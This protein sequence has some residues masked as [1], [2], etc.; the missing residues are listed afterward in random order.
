MG[1]LLFLVAVLF[2]VGRGNEFQVFQGKGLHSVIGDS[3]DKCIASHL[4]ECDSGA[5]V[6]IQAFNDQLSQLVTELWS[7]LVNSK[8]NFNLLSQF[9][10]ISALI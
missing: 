1:D 8:L 9:L 5:W 2:T 6:N 7:Q 4:L 10:L 3:P